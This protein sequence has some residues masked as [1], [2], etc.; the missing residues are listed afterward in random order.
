M[1]LKSSSDCSSGLNCI[2]KAAGDRARKRLLLPAVINGGG[3]DDGCS[4][5]GTVAAAGL[6]ANGRCCLLL[7]IGAGA[8]VTGKRDALG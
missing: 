5:S 6:G 4:G 8:M 3:D 7:W 2:Y 1:V